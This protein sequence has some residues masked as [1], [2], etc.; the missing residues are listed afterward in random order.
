[1][2]IQMQ[3]YVYLLKRT[4]DDFFNE[5]LAKKKYHF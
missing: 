1:M 2:L 5:F 3:K 4:L